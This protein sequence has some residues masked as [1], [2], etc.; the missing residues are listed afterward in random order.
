MVKTK[1]AQIEKAALPSQIT[2]N[3][4]QNYDWLTY[5]CHEELLRIFSIMLRSLGE[6]EKTGNDS[7]VKNTSQN[8]WGDEGR[9]KTAENPAVVD[10]PETETTTTAGVSCGR[11]SICKDHS[12]SLV[13][14]YERLMMNRLNKQLVIML[15]LQTSF[16]TKQTNSS[17]LADNVES[18]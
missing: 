12:S 14:W 13:P 18:C 8:L 11:C 10:I 4:A 5:L 15:N 1:I 2:V 16:I 9:V 3:Q 17:Q 6:T 7:F